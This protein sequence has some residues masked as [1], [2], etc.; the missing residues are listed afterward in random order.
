MPQSMKFAQLS[1][2]KIKQL[3]ALEDELGSI[4]LAMEPEHNFANLSA[5]QLKKLQAKEKELG[6]VL[7]AYGK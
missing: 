6:V 3:C 4:V 5:E 2:A 1:D 7:L